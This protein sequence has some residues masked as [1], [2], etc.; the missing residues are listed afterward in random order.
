MRVLAPAQRAVQHPSPPR[1]TPPLPPTRC[2]PRA[3]TTM[4]SPWRCDSTMAISPWRGHPRVVPSALLPPGCHPHA[5]ALALPHPRCRPWAAA[6][7][8]AAH[9]LLPLRCCPRHHHPR[10]LTPVLS[11]WRCD[12]AMVLSPWRC[13]PFPRRS[14]CA[15]APDSLPPRCR[16][17][18]AAER[19]TR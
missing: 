14:P 16:L 17:H 3:T 13:P 6:P 7:A 15:V 10:A 1:Y 2:R 11:P 19:R 12:S 18:A 5:D 4:M 8:A 9:A